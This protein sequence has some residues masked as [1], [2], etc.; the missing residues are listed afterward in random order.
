MRKG[1]VVLTNVGI[2]SIL[3]KN[4]LTEKD[5]INCIDEVSRFDNR[6]LA[7]YRN[8]SHN[9]KEM[10]LFSVKRAIE[11]FN[12][13]TVNIKAGEIIDF[14][15]DVI[16]TFKNNDLIT[17]YLTVN[18]TKSVKKN[19]KTHMF[20]IAKRCFGKPYVWF[21]ENFPDSEFGFDFV[22]L[23]YPDSLDFLERAKIDLSKIDRDIYNI[24]FIVYVEDKKGPKQ[25][26]SSAKLG[27]G[28]DYN[29]DFFEFELSKEANSSRGAIGFELKKQGKGWSLCTIKD[30]ISIDL[31]NFI[32]YC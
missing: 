10:N 20:V 2:E 13:S 3:E 18:Y 1:A 8:A 29:L 27:I 22:K 16:Y 15:D 9:W 30:A 11:L 4:Q 23:G 5:V 26:F 12:K 6:L 28:C 25:I 19:P 24:T 31:K 17:S 7:S 32:K 21:E 14:Y